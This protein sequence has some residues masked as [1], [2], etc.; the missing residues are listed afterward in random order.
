MTRAPNMTHTSGMTFNAVPRKTVILAVILAVLVAIFVIQERG[1]SRR[2]TV[3][4][5]EISGEIDQIRIATAEGELRFHRRADSGGDSGDNSGDA[6]GTRESADAGDAAAEWTMGEEAYPVNPD[7]VAAIEEQITALR[8]VDVVTSRGD[9]SDYGL[10]EDTVRTLR[11]FTGDLEPV[12]L[13]LGATAAAGNAVYGRINGGNEIV[14]V[15]QALDTA[16][17]FDPLRYRE[18]T[19]VAVADDEIVEVR[20]SGPGADTVRVVRRIS[21]DDGADASGNGETGPGAAD[22]DSAPA[23]GADAAPATPDTNWQLA[24][25]VAD[26]SDQPGASQFNALVRELS[27][28]E[29]TGFPEYDDAGE[30]G[31]VAGGTG[32]VSGD[33]T[34]ADPSEETR[35]PF[36]GD[37]VASVVV[38]RTDGSTVRIELWPP[39]EERVPAAASTSPYRF[40]LPE[41]RAR[42]LL[43]GIERFL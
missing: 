32:S 17:A 2:N 38:E 14:L 27:A 43:L 23:A 18:K 5:P 13:E 34:T 33:G 26:L 12:K 37:P 29:A 25:P 15:P 28:L 6:T 19:I 42:R 7:A 3:P 20:I 21:E 10:T 11:I 22:V 30:T 1:G 8:E 36:S 40:Y 39:V 16:V 9:P 41:W 31:A 24:A 35:A 4:I